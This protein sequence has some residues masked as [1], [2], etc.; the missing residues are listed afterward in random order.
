[1]PHLACTLQPSDT[2]SITTSRCQLTP[3]YH[4]WPEKPITPHC[5]TGFNEGYPSVCDYSAVCHLYYNFFTF[6]LFICVLVFLWW[7]GI[8]ILCFDDTSPWDMCMH[9]NL[10]LSFHTCLSKCLHTLR[11]GWTF[12]FVRILVC[13]ETRFIIFCHVKPPSVLCTCNHADMPFSQGVCVCLKP[14]K[15]LFPLIKGAKGSFNQGVVPMC[16]HHPGLIKG[17][18]VREEKP[19]RP[20]GSVHLTGSACSKSGSQQSATQRQE[21]PK[22]IMILI[23][24]FLP[25]FSLL[26]D[27]IHPHGVIWDR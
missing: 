13:H 18:T 16:V 15:S 2:S 21:L 8:H 11:D 25:G 22:L 19:K 1:M 7:R 4:Q 20:C 6:S 24:K 3:H 14:W 10:A 5:G 9:N 27:N 17:K 23:D 26:G 12:Q